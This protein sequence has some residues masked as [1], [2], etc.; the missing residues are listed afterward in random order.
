MKRLILLA[1]PLLMT[2]CLGLY[3]FFEVDD[4]VPRVIRKMPIGTMSRATMP[5]ASYDPDW[6]MEYPTAK[7]IDW[8]AGGTEETFLL[9]GGSLLVE[10]IRRNSPDGFLKVKARIRNQTLEFITGEYLIVFY[11][12]DGRPLLSEN[13]GFKGF[14]LGPYEAVT[15]WNGCR[16]PDAHMFRL[17]VRPA[18]PAP[19]EPDKPSN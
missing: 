17:F 3:P 13:M 19:P 18:P 6:A 9:A 5:P 15:T 1:A 4:D 10:D 12:D 7:S 16:L 11:D 14:M 8:A 2:G